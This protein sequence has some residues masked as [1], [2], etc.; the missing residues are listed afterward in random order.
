[1]FL[2]KTSKINGIGRRTTEEEP[3]TLV[4]HLTHSKVTFSLITRPNKRQIYKK[5]HSVREWIQKIHF[6]QTTT[7]E[8]CVKKT[9][10]VREGLQK[11]GKPKT[12]KSKEETKGKNH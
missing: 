4:T 7:Y 11:R 10:S 9:H 3:M 5:N 12:D 8:V 1:M 6:Q 2:S